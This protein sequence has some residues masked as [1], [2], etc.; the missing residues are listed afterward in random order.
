[1]AKVVEHQDIPLA[2]DVRLVA[3]KGSLIALDKPPGVRSH[4]N[5]DA[6]VDEKALLLAPYDMAEEAYLLGDDR[7]LFLLNRLDAP[8]S[9]LILLAFDLGTAA[10]VK[11]RFAEQEVQK[12]YFAVVVGRAGRLNT[13]WRDRLQTVRRGEGLRTVVGRGDLAVTD[14]RAV[15]ES[16]GAVPLTLIELKPHTGRTHQLRVQ[17]SARRLPIVGDATYGDF[18]A[19]RRIARDLG[20]KR[21][22]LHSS[23][24]RVKLQEKEWFQADSSIPE[25]FSR[26]VEK[27]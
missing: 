5:K 25:A 24:V 1:M 19:N 20:L 9:G 21:L 26:A 16:K 22:C 18:Q 7:Q 8:T 11:K 17:C 13:T 2:R 27:L 4:P 14:V 23:S 12:T 3:R 6:V 10:L 15:A